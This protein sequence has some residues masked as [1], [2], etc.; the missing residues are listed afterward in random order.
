METLVE[1]DFEEYERKKKA[2][3][4]VVK[5]VV[6]EVAADGTITRTVTTTTTKVETVV[7]PGDKKAVSNSDSTSTAN[8]SGRKAPTPIPSEPAQSSTQ[9]GS[10]TPAAPNDASA[11]SLAQLTGRMD[12]RATSDNCGAGE[13][14]SPAAPTPDKGKVFVDHDD[15]NTVTVGLRVYTH[16][17]VPAVIVGR[18][19][20]GSVY[21]QAQ[22]SAAESS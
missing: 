7:V 2:D 9:N 13:S 3:A 1:H 15:P 20:A 16:K 10:S 14:G 4:E 17:D 6:E 12:L 5:T 21:P 19:K 22:T 11:E 18:L 8:S